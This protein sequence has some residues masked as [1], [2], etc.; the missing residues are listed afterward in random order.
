MCRWMSQFG[1]QNCANL[2]KR[3]IKLNDEI[4][5]W[6]AYNLRIMAGRELRKVVVE[7]ARSHCGRVSLLIKFV[8]K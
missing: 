6:V 3:T 1:A 5:A 4:K 8:S 2:I 7:G